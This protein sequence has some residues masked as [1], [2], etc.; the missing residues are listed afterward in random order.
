MLR[1]Y[2]TLRYIVVGLSL[3]WLTQV[4]ALAFIEITCSVPNP[5]VNTGHNVSALYTVWMAKNIQ[6]FLV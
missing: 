4:N 1:K 2:F 5:V 3:F 6:A